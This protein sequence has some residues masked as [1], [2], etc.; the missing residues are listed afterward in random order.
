[1]TPG[2]S[3]WVWSVVVGDDVFV[4]SATSGSRW[5]AA[6]FAKAAAWSAR[7]STAGRSPSIWSSTRPSRIRSTRRIARSTRVI[8]IFP[9]TC[10]SDRVIRSRGCVP[11]PTSPDPASPHA[12][13]GGLGA[14]APSP[15]F[16]R[17]VQ[18]RRSDGS[19][20]AGG[21]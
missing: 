9:R 8:R 18:R 12:C 20:T 5:F 19:V 17:V 1:M 10:S 4:R 11:S 16:R 6:P 15:P 7:S 3:I 14:A 21:V 2:T 13:Y